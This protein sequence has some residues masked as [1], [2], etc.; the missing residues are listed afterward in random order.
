MAG[1]SLG[2]KETQA[3]IESLMMN[4]LAE[5]LNPLFAAAQPEILNG[6]Q[7]D[8][9]LGLQSTDEYGLLTTGRWRGHF[10]FEQGSEHLRLDTI[11]AVIANSVRIEFQPFTYK[12]GR[13]QGGLT[14]SMLVEDYSDILSLKQAI[15][16]NRVNIPVDLPWLDWLLTSG[17][18]TPSLVAGYHIVFGNDGAKRNRNSRSGIAIMAPGGSW[19][20]PGDGS[21]N[22]NWLTR[23]FTSQDFLDRMSVRIYKAIEG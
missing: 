3:E 18:M 6:I 10:G 13:F 8:I 9:L 20:V 2:L 22:D 19:V 23:F 11:I 14:L 12:N 7:E 5:E 15:V 21:P 16:E 1:I 17:G 4:A